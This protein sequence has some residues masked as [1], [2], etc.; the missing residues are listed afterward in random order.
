MIQR[1]NAAGARGT[2]PLAISTRGD[3]YGMEEGA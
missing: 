2:V 1:A 3:Y